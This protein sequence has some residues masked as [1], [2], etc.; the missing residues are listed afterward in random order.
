MALLKL[1]KHASE[2]EVGERPLLSGEP[3]ILDFAISRLFPL[4]PI[5]LSIP[6]D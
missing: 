3:K 5:Y 4:H 1:K 6:N 2:V